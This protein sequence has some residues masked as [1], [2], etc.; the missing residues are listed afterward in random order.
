[1]RRGLGSTLPRA[2]DP[3]KGVRG[4]VGGGRYCVGMHAPLGA[5]VLQF[6][7][8]ADR[9]ENL[10]RIEA[11]A[12]TA[13]DRGARLVV[14]PEYSAAFEP[15][16]GEWMRR[17]AEPLDG[18]F[19]EGLRRIAVG[20]GAVIV[21]GLLE[22]VDD[23]PN[24]CKS[25]VA[26]SPDG[27]VLARS[28]KIHLYDAFGAGESRWIS[29]G[30]A[31]AVP[32]TFELEG[33]RIGMQT[34]YDLRFP[35]VSRR[36][37]DTGATAIVIPAAWMRGPLKEHHWSTLLRARAIENCA[38]VIAA[39]QAPPVA[40]GRSAIVGPAGVDVAAVG[41]REGLA[42]AWLEAREVER[43]RADNPAISLRRYRTAIRE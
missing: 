43:V 6:A 5:A 27:A 4:R 39:D 36:L 16:L 13:A 9:A 3:D 29:A 15:E 18:P 31:A 25:L 8:S 12:R 24:P 42:I 35:E 21:A 41:A 19:V 30:D 2:G 23:A 38:Y 20:T 11:E 22:A 32:E 28:R 26:V 1:M 40:V 33:L 34:C 7:P 17:V 37:L 14:A 10:A